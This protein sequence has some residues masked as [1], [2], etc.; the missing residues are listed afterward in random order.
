M[1]ID[2]NQ[3]SWLYSNKYNEIYHMDLGYKRTCS[4]NNFTTK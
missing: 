4:I 1:V 2:V 3:E